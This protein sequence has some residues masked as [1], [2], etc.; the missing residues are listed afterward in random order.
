[1]ALPRDP[2]CLAFTGCHALS[3]TASN[4]YTSQRVPRTSVD[5]Q[6]AGGDTEA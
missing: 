2:H 4:H 3:T 6:F 5:L 1:M